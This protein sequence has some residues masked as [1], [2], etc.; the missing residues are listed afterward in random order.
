VADGV[1]RAPIF[2]V[3]PRPSADGPPVALTTLNSVRMQRAAVPV[4]I[5]QPGDGARAFSQIALFWN[6]STE[7]TRA[8]AGALPFLVR[9]EHVTGSA[10]R[11]RG[12]VSRRRTTSRLISAVTASRPAIAKG[13]VRKRARPAACCLPP[14]E[15]PKPISW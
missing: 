3:M 11:R 7:A 15:K 9:A 2:T 13:A 14:P 8:V 12:M 6:G 1:L 4:L 5:V 10:R